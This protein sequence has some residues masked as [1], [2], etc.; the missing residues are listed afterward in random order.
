LSFNPKNQGENDGNGTAKQASKQAK[1]F[2]AALQHVKF[3][4][5]FALKFFSNPNN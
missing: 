3:C 4:L 2:C 5:S 1:Y